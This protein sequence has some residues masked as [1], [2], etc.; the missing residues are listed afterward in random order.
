MSGYRRTILVTG[1]GAFPG[2]PS[3]P[4]AAILHNLDRHRGRLARLGVALHGILLPVRYADA[5]DTLRAAVA[6]FRPDVILHLGV[7]MRRREISVEIRGVNRADPLHFDAARQRPNQ[8]LEPGAPHQLRASIPAA[9]LVAATRAAGYAAALSYDAGGYVCN[10]TLY[11]SLLWRLAPEVG[12]LHVPAT[13]SRVQPSSR[14]RRA[15]PTVEMLTRAILR[16]VLLLARS[17]V[18]YA[19]EEP[20][21]LNPEAS[22]HVA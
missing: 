14:V 20:Q 13:R 15:K 7:A 6:A 16:M 22:R 8:I 17:P 21:R 12:F 2:V 4:T 19:N 5:D 3:N 18:T 1:F 11:R 10:A 9:G